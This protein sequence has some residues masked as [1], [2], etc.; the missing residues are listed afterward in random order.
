VV[1]CSIDFAEEL[2]GAK[3]LVAAA[4]ALRRRVFVEPAAVLRQRAAHADLDV[5]VTVDILTSEVNVEGVRVTHF[6]R[7]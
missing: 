4:R 2:V 7:I 3:E 1:L 5:A 6:S